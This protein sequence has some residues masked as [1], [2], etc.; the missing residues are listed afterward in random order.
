MEKCD[1]CLNSRLIVSENGYHSIC[2]LSQKE[3]IN[4]MTDEKNQFITLKTFRGVK[5]VQCESRV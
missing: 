5:H 4:C 2:T 3:A 1:E